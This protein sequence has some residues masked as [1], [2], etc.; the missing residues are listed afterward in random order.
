MMEQHDPIRILV[1]DDHP[2]VREGLTA[3][4]N[5]QPGME[6]VAEARDGA[7]AVEIFHKAHPDITMVDLRMPK[8]DGI[9]V[10]SKIRELTPDARVIM[11]S[12]FDGDENIYQSLRAG[13]KGYL[14]KD[15]DCET[16][17]ECIQAVNHGQSWVQPAV[18]QRLADR[19]SETELSPRELQV[20]QC[21]VNGKT[22]KEIG[23]LLDIGE[24]TVKIHV[25]H[26]LKKLGVKGRTE[27]INVALKRGIVFLD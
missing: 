12:T 9:Q 2:V 27:A 14:R 22:N 18:A 11:I 17:V 25:N 5:R 19:V 3:L 15:A 13:A 4:I 20:L 21:M 7:E 16:L 10:I 23:N 26:L 8:M 24:G 1:A 6:V